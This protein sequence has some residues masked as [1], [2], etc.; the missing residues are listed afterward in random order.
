[1]ETRKRIAATVVTA[2]L[3][4]GLAL[5]FSGCSKENALGP[6]IENEKPDFNILSFGNVQN[7]LK[8]T[9]KVSKNIKKAYGGTLYLSDEF[10]TDDE[11]V[12]VDIRLKIHPN[13]IPADDEF[14]MSIDSDQFLANLDVVFGPHG[15]KFSKPA[16][17][18]INIQGLDLSGLDLNT[19]QVYYDNQDT[20]QWEMMECD[21][22]SIDID[23]GEIEVINAK[24]PHF[25]RYALAH[26]E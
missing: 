17:L 5:N 2:L 19:I 16:E 24:L 1:M 8:K 12:D 21:E 9:I 6:I 14:L 15:M 7:S 10:E 3:T 4:V 22:I 11:E 23:N 20:G 13:S 26:S 25:S 18:T